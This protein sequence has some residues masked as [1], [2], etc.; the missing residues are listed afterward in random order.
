MALGEEQAPPRLVRGEDKVLNVRLNDNKTGNPFDISAATEIKAILLKETGY[1][2]KLLSTAGITITN[3]PG[4][5]LAIMVP[6][7]EGATLA[8]SGPG[9]LSDIEIHV[10]IAGKVTYALLDDVFEVV[11]PFFP[12]AV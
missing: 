10:T 1:L 2:I 7:A 5:R 6:K 4:G 8:L 3:G 11:D 9:L 12:D